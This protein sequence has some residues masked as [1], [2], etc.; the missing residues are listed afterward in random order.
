MDPTCTPEGHR[1]EPVSLSPVPMTR[2]HSRHLFLLPLNCC[3]HASDTHTLPPAFGEL[4]ARSAHPGNKLFWRFFY[5]K[6]WCPGAPPRRR[7]QLE[8]EWAV[9]RAALPTPSSCTEPARGRGP[10]SPPASHLSGT[11]HLDLG[12]FWSNLQLPACTQSSLQG[13][14]NGPGFQSSLGGVRWSLRSPW[15]PVSHP[16]RQLRRVTW[17][18]SVHQTSSSRQPW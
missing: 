5:C 3:T 7:T 9:Q 18:T 10:K 16:G 4:S 6:G 11:R 2:S 13:E 17:L 8:E 15:G 14:D 12:E 1:L